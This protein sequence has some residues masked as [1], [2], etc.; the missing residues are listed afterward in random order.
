MILLDPQLIAFETIVKAGTVNG[1]AELLFLTQTAVT[2]R[3]RMLEQKM[4]TTLFLRSRR[5]M[6]LTPEGEALHRYCQRVVEMEG[7]V[8][9]LIQGGGVTTNIRMKVAGPSSIMRTRIIP[10]CEAVMKEFPYLNMSFQIDDDPDLNQKLKSGDCDLA[11]LSPEYVAAEMDHKPLESEYY[12]LVCTNQWNNRTLRDILTHEKIIDFDPTDPMSFSYLKHYGFLDLIQSERHFVNNTESIAQL[13]ASG[14][15]YGVLTTEFAEPY[16]KE[17][18]LMVLNQTKKY[19]N[20]V[21]LAWYPRSE[22]PA[23]FSA[24]IKSIQ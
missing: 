24:L 11:I 5:G 15:G 3:L 18:T 17:G 8:L 16:L 22:Q 6:L 12:L 7:A 1:A 21:S 20:P 14:F 13:F 10:Q 23:Y 9:A 4:K 19:E 2:Q